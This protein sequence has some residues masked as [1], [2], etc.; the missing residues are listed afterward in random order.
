[1]P[2]AESHLSKAIAQLEAA[3]DELEKE[4]N[5]SSERIEKRGWLNDAMSEVHQS[6]SEMLDI[7]SH[8]QR[9]REEMQDG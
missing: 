1:M 9:R 3:H 6:K 4:R 5:K 7:K 8:L 2:N